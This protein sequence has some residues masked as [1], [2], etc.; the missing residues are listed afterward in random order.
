VA[1]GIAVPARDGHTINVTYEEYNTWNPGLYEYYTHDSAEY[2][3]SKFK[4]EFTQYFNMDFS[5]FYYILTLVLLMM[6]SRAKNM[7]LASWD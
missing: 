5:L 4:S 1:H 7:M 3:L 6:D 2:R